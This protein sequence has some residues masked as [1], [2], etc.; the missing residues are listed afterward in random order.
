MPDTGGPVLADSVTK[1]GPDAAGRVVVSGSHGGIYAAA[2]A[3]KAGCRAVILHDAGVGLDRA[4]IGGLDWLDARGMAAAAVGHASAPIGQA[5]E[6]LATGRISHANA[7]ARACGVR[8][9]MECARA[10]RLLE[11]ARSP[12][13]PC[14]DVAEAREV[15][16]FPGARRALVLVDSAS[17]VQPA[18]TGQVVATG[19]H[20]AVF[21]ADP[22]NALK[23]DAFLALFNDAGGG[24]GTGR[25]VVLEA[26]GIAAATVA[27][28]SARIGQGRSTW[29]DGVISALNARAAALGGAVGQP[30]RRL[31][32]RAL[33]AED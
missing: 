30:A 28:S 22:R 15:L 29:Q 19:S 33:Q 26:R 25:L 10:A 7:Q 32:A 24:P 23:A 9:G 18:D 3:C 6:M 2:L 1:L 4:G 31:I 5:A 16:H 8:A 11:K 13:G 17:L 14:P 21:G 12:E 20:G 27:A